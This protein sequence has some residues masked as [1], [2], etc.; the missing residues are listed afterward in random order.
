MRPLSKSALLTWS[1]TIRA[2]LSPAILSSASGTD[3][4]FTKQLCDDLN[5]F[6]CELNITALDRDLLKTSKIHIALSEM[7][8][9]GGGWPSGF[10][11][12]AER[13][14]EKMEK[15]LGNLEGLSGGLWDDSGRL[16]R[17][18]EVKDVK[19]RIGWVIGMKEGQAPNHAEKSSDL[20]FRVG[21]SEITNS[22]YLKSK[23]MI[24]SWWINAAAAV[25]DG[26]IT[27]ISKAITAESVPSR[28]AYAFLMTGDHEGPSSTDNTI[29]L[30]LRTHAESSAFM[31]NLSEHKPI[32]I[33][34]DHELDS[35][36]APNAGVRYDGL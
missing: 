18:Q 5:N 23:L 34:R 24:S 17:C 19:G 2:E 11:D 30:V 21:R 35:P 33:L 28:K 12:K 31:G 25:R 27:H 15:D 7:A 22:L 4:L 29:K 32:R 36:R 20:G 13:A 16:E 9:P 1:Y 6:F 26:I 8:E 10:V 3:R 14:M